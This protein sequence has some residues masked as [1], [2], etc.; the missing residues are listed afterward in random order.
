MAGNNNSNNMGFVQRIKKLFSKDDKKNKN[1]EELAKVLDEFKSTTPKSETLVKT[2]GV[3]DIIRRHTPFGIARIEGRTLEI[4]YLDIRLIDVLKR[5]KIVPVYSNNSENEIAGFYAI[6]T[7]ALK[8]GNFNV[9]SVNG[10]E[11]RVCTVVA[12]ILR[13]VEEG[14]MREEER[15]TVDAVLSS[16]EDTL[17]PGSTT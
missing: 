16:V 6:N 11:V 13:E 1:R 3:K 9:V 17:K 2:A 4:D 5:F 10:K 14:A 15:L 7:R 12:P 8:F